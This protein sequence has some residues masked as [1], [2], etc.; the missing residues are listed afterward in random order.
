MF[1]ELCIGRTFLV[2]VK[3]SMGFLA[4]TGIF[5]SRTAT[6]IFQKAHE[7]EIILYVPRKGASV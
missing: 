7:P 1:L 6:N 3:S 2:Y 4:A 5:F